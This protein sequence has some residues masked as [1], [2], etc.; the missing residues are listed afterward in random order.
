MSFATVLS[1]SPEDKI[2]ETVGLCSDFIRI[3]HHVNHSMSEEFA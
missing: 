3:S 2:K 1:E